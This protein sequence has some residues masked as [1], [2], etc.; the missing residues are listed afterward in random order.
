MLERWF[1]LNFARYGNCN[2]FMCGSDEEKDL[3]CKR[4]LL[5]WAIESN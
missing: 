3:N 4:M 1:N 5:L 2:P